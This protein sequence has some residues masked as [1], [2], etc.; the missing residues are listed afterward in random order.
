MA[1][2]SG[3][4][5]GNND[6]GVDQSQP[7]QT[8]WVLDMQAWGRDYA[9]WKMHERSLNNPTPPFPQSSGD[10]IIQMF[11]PQETGTAVR[12]NSVEWSK[13]IGDWRN[14]TDAYGRTY[15]DMCPKVQEQQ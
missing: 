5:S 12:S 6:M 8:A 10:Q 15:E 7:S 9:T 13:L 4:G 14:I 3:S 1:S 2:G 11:L